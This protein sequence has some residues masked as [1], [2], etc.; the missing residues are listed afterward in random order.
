MKKNMVPKIIFLVLLII[1]VAMIVIL[2][3]SQKAKELTIFMYNDICEKEK[4][5]FSVKEVNTE[6][7][8]S[9][10]VSR[11]DESICI[12]SISNGEHTSTKQMDILFCIMKKNITFMI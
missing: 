12:D 5:Y 2:I 1:L 8:N 4:Y 6:T 7:D 11:N 3:I 10:I 9:L